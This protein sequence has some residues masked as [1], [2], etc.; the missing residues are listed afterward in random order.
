MYIYRNYR[1]QVALAKN[2]RCITLWRKY[3]DWLKKELIR[4]D[5]NYL[6]GQLE[7][8]SKIV[9]NHYKAGFIF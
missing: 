3:L 4:S 5:P 6:R 9:G 8:A 7:N 2:P 1:Y